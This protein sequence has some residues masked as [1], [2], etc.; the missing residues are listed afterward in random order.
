MSKRLT[1]L[2]IGILTLFALSAIA[3]ET[4]VATMGNS[5]LYLK[6]DAGIFFYP[7]TMGM[8]Q[9][10]I[11]AEHQGSDF[12]NRTPFAYN[13]ESRVG[14]VMPAWGNGTL[15]I[16]AGEGT[17]NFNV[18]GGFNNGFFAPTTRFLVGYGLNTG[19]SALGFQVDFSGVKDENVG[20]PVQGGTPDIFTAS[21]WGFGFGLSTPMG[22]LNNLDFG[23]RLRIGSFEDKRDSA[24][25]VLAN[26]SDGN[27]ALSFVVR[28]YYALNDYL[29][30]VPVGALGIASEKNIEYFGGDST[31]NKFNTTA[32]E[33][34]LALQTKP[35]ENSEIIGGAGYRYFKLRER[36]FD[37]A[38]GGDTLFTDFSESETSLPFAF[39]GFEAQVKSWMHFRMGVEKAITQFKEKSDKPVAAASA[40]EGRN[41]FKETDSPFNYAVGVAFHAGPVTMDAQV[42]NEWWN[43]FP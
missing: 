33:V 1:L 9:K 37:D 21:T 23:F 26:K 25:E 28:D 29:N 31:L 43:R 14:I 15:A 38:S 40:D 32:L 8:Y 20:S 2:T 34:G 22:D 35:T 36:V 18:G 41:E 7:G 11:V 27:T 19:N 5:G 6:D 39:L 17:E 3:T 4:R 13:S 24:T 12:T 16:F 42:A 10:M 30:L